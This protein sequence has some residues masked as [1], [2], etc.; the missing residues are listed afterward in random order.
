MLNRFLALFSFLAIFLISVFIF[1][2][3]RIS[4]RPFMEPL[5]TQNVEYN[6][7][8]SPK[9]NYLVFQSNRPGGKGGMDIWITENKSYPNRMKFPEWTAP[10]NFEELN[11]P[12]FEGLFS[13]YFD[14]MDDKPNEIYF[15]SLQSEFRDG[16]KG[17][18]LYF[19]ERIAG[20]KNWKKPIHLNEVNSNFNDRMPAISPDGKIL[21]FSSDRP[22]GLGGFD[23][24]VSFR[25]NNGS[26]WSE[27]LNMGSRINSSFNE[28]APSFHWDGETLYFSSDR[29]NPAKKFKI[30]R[31][32]WLENGDCR[33]EGYEK[34]LLPYR[35]ICWESPA[36]L[37]YPFNTEFFEPETSVGALDRYDPKIPLNDYRYSDNEGLS[38]SYD[39]LWV[40]FASNRPGGLGQFD[41]YRSPMP[42][43]MRKSY[44]FK[45]NG[46]V[47]DG[48]EK[49]MIGLDSTLKIFDETQ[50]I[51]VITSSRIGGNL[52]PTIKEEKVKNF[53][54]I[55]KTGR[56][57]RVEVSSPGFYPTEILVDLRGNI[58]R[59]KSRYE[60]IV[61][62]KIKPEKL[63]V[64][65]IE[66]TVHDKKTGEI[67]KNSNVTLF[68]SKIRE[69]SKITGDQG[70]FNLI[71]YPEED[72]E[73]HVKADGYKTDT[74]FFQLKEIPEMVGKSKKLFLTNLNDIDQIFSITI[75][76]P[77]NIGDISNEDKKK[78]DSMAS[79]LLSHPKETLE[80]GGHTDNVASKEYNIKLSHNRAESVKNYLLKKGVPDLRM[81]IKAYYYSQPVEDNSTEKGRSKNRR[82]NFKKVE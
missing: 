72:F 82:V 37:G 9:G 41:I 45:F 12:S 53:E 24:W 59:G 75:Y 55:L 79:Y 80:I 63:P 68:T 43:D 17:L 27:P 66:L 8:I 23:L 32:N 47:L 20:S 30:L 74:F 11:T 31:S 7:I 51:K 38:V 69:G 60:T 65:G 76:F 14:S 19:T 34:L 71:Q 54:T 26:K 18:N 64:Q 10:E 35:E 81:K 67:I 73:L 36:D 2:E 56:L 13:I 77:T 4:H 6:P 62:E 57:Y 16:Y 33:T 78:L 3:D 44:E 40:Y 1:A 21:V 58:G 42:D 50:P 22:G 15:T 46:L 5:N 29:A 48:S 39:D 52:Q 25:Y 28:I 49:L 61:L 70:V